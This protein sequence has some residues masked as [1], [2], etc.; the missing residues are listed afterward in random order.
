[1]HG[2]RTRQ[3]RCTSSICI[4]GRFSASSPPAFAWTS[5]RRRTMRE[6]RQQRKPSAFRGNSANA[7]RDL[8]QP[9]AARDSYQEAL[10]IRRELARQRPDAFLAGVAMTLNNLGA[11]QSDLGQPEAARDSYQEALQIRRELARQRPDA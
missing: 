11:A 2:R 8:R 6:Y 5:K 7:Q 3:R 1:M 9:E 4:P 10:Q